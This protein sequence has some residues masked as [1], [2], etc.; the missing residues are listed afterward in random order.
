MERPLEQ[1]HGLSAERVGANL[2]TRRQMLAGIGGVAAAALVTPSSVLASAL[3][4][5][6]PAMPNLPHARRAATITEPQHLSWVWQFNHDGDPYEVRDTLAEHGMGI[7]LKTHDG[8]NWMSRYDHT[9][10]GIGGPA[11][12]EA[13]ADFF[14]RGGVPF[15]AWTVLKGRNPRREARLASEVLNAGARSLFLDVEGHP[16]FWEG[17]PE[18]AWRFGQ[19]LREKQPNARLSISIDPR[20]WELENIPLAA[21]AD[22]A[23]EIAPQ[24]YW[25]IFA[26]RDNE[27]MYVKTGDTIP[28]KG[29]TSGFVISS[30]MRRLAAYGLPIHPIGDGTVKGLD[31]WNEFIDQSYAMQADAVSV[32]RHGVAN[33]DI[34][35]FLRDTPTRQSSY[36]VQWGDTLYSIARRFR[37]TVPVLVAANA[38]ADPNAV[39]V[40]TRLRIAYGATGGGVVA[41]AAAGPVS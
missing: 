40:G 9:P 21:F 37:T 33:K 23:D 17:T 3:D 38:I 22:F 30:A 24:V 14:E 5:V 19:Y 27:S 26:N 41:G 29:I 31:G 10:T 4:G 16:G 1:L 32:W 25:S 35:R 6:A 28:V 18:T 39:P 12:V 15:H 8:V 2:V 36:V 13:Y 34:F 11:H 7:V 20:P